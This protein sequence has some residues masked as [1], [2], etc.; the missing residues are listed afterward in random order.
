M[1]ASDLFTGDH[2][3][4]L[5]VSQLIGAQFARIRQIVDQDRFPYSTPNRPDLPVTVPNHFIWRQNFEP[6]SLRR[7]PVQKYSLLIEQN[8][9]PF[10][11]HRPIATTRPW[12]SQETFEFFV[13]NHSA[14]WHEIAKSAQQ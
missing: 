9:T 4:R 14:V 2:Q 11:G 7:A 12:N 6:A 1:S 13:Q 8:T 5:I 3:T 10:G